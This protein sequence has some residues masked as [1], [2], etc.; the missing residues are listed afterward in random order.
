MLLPTLCIGL[1]CLDGKPEDIAGAP[2]NG[3]SSVCAL[4]RVGAGDQAVLDDTNELAVKTA[5]H[6][7]G[8]GRNAFCKLLNVKHCLQLQTHKP[9]FAV[10]GQLCM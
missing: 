7:I 9:E 4:L 2:V 10:C 1:C 5:L 8:R 3:P 6:N